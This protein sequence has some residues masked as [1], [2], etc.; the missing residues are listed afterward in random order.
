VMGKFSCCLV[1]PTDMS[2][3]VRAGQ[4][5]TSDKMLKVLRNARAVPEARWATAKS[6]IV[7]AML[8]MARAASTGLTEVEEAEARKRVEGTLEKAR[9]MSDT[10]FEMNKEELC[11]D[12][13]GRKTA[14][15]TE[16][17]RKFRQAF[18]LLLPGNVQT[19]DRLLARQK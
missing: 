7:Q 12:L 5:E 2:D 18:F 1:P 3:P 8:E 19:Y 11:R 17:Y 15:N 6:R 4:A 14:Q 9:S 10:D 13:K 16:S